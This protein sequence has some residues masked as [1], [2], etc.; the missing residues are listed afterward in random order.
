VHRLPQ[1]CEGRLDPGGLAAGAER[2][3]DRMS[4]PEQLSRRHKISK[5]LPQPRV[6][7]HRFGEVVARADAAEDMDCG[8]DIIFGGGGRLVGEAL[9]HQTT[10]QTF[11]MQ[12]AGFPAGVEHLVDQWSRAGEIAAE[13]V[14]LG[15]PQGPAQRRLA[16]VKALKPGDCLGEFCNPGVEPASLDMSV[17]A[18]RPGI[19]DIIGDRCEGER[20]VAA[21]EPTF[22]ITPLNMGGT[23]AP[24]ADRLEAQVIERGA[25]IE[26]ATTVVEAGIPLAE[27]V[28]RQAQMP[29][30][31]SRPPE[32]AAG[33]KD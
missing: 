13:K 6:R 8:L 22:Q 24:P 32:I 15:K 25:V 11:E 9:A 12:I 16:Q 14:A 31:S 21:F 7:H 2:F 5:A 23:H 28:C 29:Q 10:G 30:R 19:R 4:L 26:R 18:N 33:F 27:R 20:F 3:E 1:R 17:A